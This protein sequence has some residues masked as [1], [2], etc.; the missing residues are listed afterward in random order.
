MDNLEKNINELMELKNTIREIR[1]VCTSFNSRIDQVEERILEVKDQLN[2][3][4]REDKIREKRVKRNEQNLQEIWGY[5]KRPNLR[6]IGIPE[7]DEENESNLV[8]TK[9]WYSGGDGRTAG[10]QQQ[11]KEAVIRTG[12]GM[13]T[14][15]REEAKEAPCALGTP[16][17]G[18]QLSAQQS[19]WKQ[20]T[21]KAVDE[22][23]QAAV[24]AQ[25]HQAEGVQDV[26]GGGVVTPVSVA[27]PPGHPGHQQQVVE[28]QIEAGR[29]HQQEGGHKEGHRQAGGHVVGHPGCAAGSL[30]EGPVGQAQVVGEPRQQREHEKHAGQSQAEQVEMQGLAQA[31]A[32]VDK[33]CRGR[34]NPRPSAKAKATS[35]MK[36]RA[37]SSQELQLATPRSQALLFISDLE[38]NV[39][40]HTGTHTVSETQTPQA[41]KNIWAYSYPLPKGDSLLPR[42]KCSG[43]ILARC[44]LRLPSSSDSPAS[45][46]RVAGTTDVCHHNQLIFVLLVATGFHY[47]GQ[48]VFL[49]LPR[50]ECNGT[51]LSHHN[52]HLPG[53]SDSPASASRVAG[54]T[55]MCHH[56]QLIFRDGF[57]RVGQAGLPTSG[58]P[59]TSAY[60][61]AGITGVS[62]RAR[63]VNLVSPLWEFHSPAMSLTTFLVGLRAGRHAAAAETP[64]R[65]W[66]GCRCSVTRLEL[67]RLECNGVILAHRNLCLP[68]SSNS[69]AS[70]S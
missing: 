35:T 38:I 8:T 31:P 66:L 30:W 52:L 16:F 20:H 59:P 55:G 22:R 36:K 9:S 3:M 48:A 56:T 61:S 24:E 5:V 44:N 17:P 37:G 29:K 67:P 54:I 43:T 10:I 40:T 4:K 11:E 15:G 47:V 18:Q 63:P 46:S 23:V 62:H 1:E 33:H 64:G 14:R 13:H 53:S 2:E 70:A 60:Q 7:S 34:C 19:W 27:A 57:L 51:I 69:P 12:L 32:A 39:Y 41:H 25:Q 68:G 58:D 65:R 50:L 42:L 45:A 28:R 6:L 21:K 49:L 26:D